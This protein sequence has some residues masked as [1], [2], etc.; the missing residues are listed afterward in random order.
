MTRTTLHA[1]LVAAAAAIAMLLN[2]C[3]SMPQSYSQIS[4][5]DLRGERGLQVMKRDFTYCSDAIETRRS[6]H[7]LCMSERGWALAK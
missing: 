6:L 5:Q 7:E 3:T 1:G 4:W 2:A